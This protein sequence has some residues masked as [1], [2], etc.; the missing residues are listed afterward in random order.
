MGMSGRM[1]LDDKTSVMFNTVLGMEL[2]GMLEWDQQIA[3][4]VFDL[5][6][7]DFENIKTFVMGAAIE[8]QFSENIT[9]GVVFSSSCNKY[10]D[11]VNRILK[12]QRDKFQKQLYVF[13]FNYVYKVNN[14]MKVYLTLGKGFK[15]SETNKK[16]E[17]VFR[18]HFNLDS[19]KHYGEND[20]CC[21]HYIKY[22][23]C[24]FGFYCFKKSQM[25]S[26]MGIK[27]P[28]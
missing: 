26:K 6:S 17:S 22:S 13:A 7:S 4:F 27:D 5:E 3:L 25:L 12:S 23:F 10:P 19:G 28:R 24:I 18:H 8:R 16:G 1:P 9:A 2:A 11:I 20:C 14:A 21:Q 15:A